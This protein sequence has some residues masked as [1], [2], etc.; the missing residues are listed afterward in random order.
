MARVSVWHP[1]SA[2][3]DEEI[4]SPQGVSGEGGVELVEG[5]PGELEWRGER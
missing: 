3:G 5:V 2:S 4:V 1:I